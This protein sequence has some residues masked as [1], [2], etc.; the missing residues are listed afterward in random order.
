MDAYADVLALLTPGVAELRGGVARWERG[1][2]D[3]EKRRK[4]TYPVFME[5][6]P[7][8]W[9]YD[10]LE[11]LERIGIST[12]YYL[13][14]PGGR[15]GI[16]HYDFALAVQQVRWKLHWRLSPQRPGSAPVP[17][18]WLDQLS[19]SKAFPPG[20]LVRLVGEYAEELALVGE[21]PAPL[22][23]VM[24]ALER[25]LVERTGRQKKIRQRE[26]GASPPKGDAYP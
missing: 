2:D 20:L 3:P 1:R 17:Q 14:K 26:T 7:E 8:H 15:P 9:P 13:T 21:E 18:E 4:E 5:V 23:E 10:A 6:S 19:T 25:E 16:A 12:P 22:R 24:A 11:R